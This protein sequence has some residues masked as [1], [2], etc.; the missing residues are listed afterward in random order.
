MIEFFQAAIA[1]FTLPFTI[2]LGMVVLY[3]LIVILGALDMEALEAEW[4]PD[5]DVD[6]DGFLHGVF[7]F[8]SIGEVPI[9]MVLSI[10]TLCGWAISLLAN[11]FLNPAGMLAIGFGILAGNLVLSLL[12]TSLFT[13]PLRK[14]FASMHRENTEDQQIMYRP[15]VVTTSVV[16]ER[17]GQ[18]EIKTGGA[19]IVI[20]A[21]TTDSV[22]LKKGEKVLIFEEDKEKGIYFVSRFDD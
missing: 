9:M 13:R 21:R 7:D 5:L 18:V 22:E 15:G 14:I 20:N 17:F 10:M 2:L 19:P 3:W 12:L 16:N 6:A 4:M 1:P 11:Y 8:L